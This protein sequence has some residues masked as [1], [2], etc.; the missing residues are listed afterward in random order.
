LLKAIN[1]ALRLYS[2]KTAWEKIAV[3]N[4]NE[5][6][7]WKQQVSEYDEIYKLITK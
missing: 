2:N 6:Y 3:H 7:S 4:M 1:K 5:D